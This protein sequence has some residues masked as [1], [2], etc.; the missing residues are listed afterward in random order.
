MGSN[1]SYFKNAGRDAPVENVSWDDCQEFLKN[2]CQMEGAVE[3]TYR[4]LTE[5]EWEYACRAGTQ[6][7]LYNGD[8]T[9]KGENNVPALDAI[10][11]YGGN[12]GVDYEGA[13]DS[14]GWPERQY[15]HKRAGTH[16]VGSKRANGFG[17][18]DMIGNVW[19]WCQDW[20]GEYPSGPLT[21]PLGT[22][23]GVY[24]FRIFRGG[25]WWGRH[26]T[27]CC[28]SAIRGGGPPGASLNNF[29]L[30]LARTIPSYP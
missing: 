22:P 24:R 5:A 6:T 4:F 8:L 20:S 2:L 25:C 12:S 1:P 30:R 28:R 26:H 23:S 27:A 21:D 3:G 10:A 7:A 17:L 11:W 19:E 16:P 9:I 29:G 18:C 14:S 13:K 15:D